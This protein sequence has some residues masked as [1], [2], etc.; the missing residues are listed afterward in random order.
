MR[1]WHRW[2]RPKEVAYPEL[3]FRVVGEATVAREWEAGEATGPLEWSARMQKE[4]DRVTWTLRVDGVLTGTE[5][6][7]GE[8]A[9]AYAAGDQCRAAARRIVDDYNAFR[10]AAG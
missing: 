4:S 6:R 3:R 2:K 8:A 9:N 10:E 7:A 1:W 5:R